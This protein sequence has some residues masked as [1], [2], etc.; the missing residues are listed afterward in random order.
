MRIFGLTAVA[1]AAG[2]GLVAGEANAT[3]SLS[4]GVT[5]GPDNVLFN[6]GLCVTGPAN[7]VK[8]SV[9]GFLVDFTTTNSDS[10]NLKV[11]FGNG[12]QAKVQDGGG[13]LFYNIS[14]EMEGA[15]YLRTVFKVTP[16]PTNT[17]GTFDITVTTKV[18]SGGS[19]IA[20]PTY[21]FL[22]VTLS[23]PNGGFF[24]LE[25]SNL[26]L[27]TATEFID[28]VTFDADVGSG[29]KHDFNGFTDIRQIRIGK[30]CT[31]TDIECVNNEVP[32]P[33]TLALL[34]SG[35]LG[36]GLVRRRRRS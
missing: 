16:D 30:I 14:Y 33:A 9:D 20:G 36:L 27:G 6:C 7:P 34:G 31:T 26:D 1:L 13:G 15:V 5:P 29:A 2:L 11:N 23:G 3:V 32:E 35:L 22:D 19:F 28:T 25:E 12:G 17:D 21:T 24:T 4:S 10:G 8:G 18:L